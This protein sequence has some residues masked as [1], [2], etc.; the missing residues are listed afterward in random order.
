MGNIEQHLSD[1]FAFEKRQP[2]RQQRCP[3]DRGQALRHRLG[4]W[5]QSLAATA[6]QEERLHGV[7]PAGR[8][9]LVSS[10]LTHDTVTSEHCPAP[11]P[12]TYYDQ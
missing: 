9:R 11:L 10:S 5:S 3:I 2:Q 6:W 1:A 4:E 12:G 8:S 7:K